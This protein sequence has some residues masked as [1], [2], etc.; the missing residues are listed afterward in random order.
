MEG[1]EEGLIVIRLGYIS[2][3][4]LITAVNCGEDGCILWRVNE[5]VPP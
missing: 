2:H 1:R 5:F 3:L 4:V